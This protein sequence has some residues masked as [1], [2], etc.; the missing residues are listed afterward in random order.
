MKYC[1]TINDKRYEIEVER[2][3]AT[4]VSTTEIPLGAV[5]NKNPVNLQTAATSVT[6]KVIETPEQIT[7]ESPGVGREV[8]KAPMAGGITD[9]KV[10]VG[11][12]VRIGDTLIILEAMKMENDITAHVDGIVTEIKVTRGENVSVGDV[13]VVLK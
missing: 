6:P 11:S 1:V 13:L 7:E 3:D 10:S 12:S 9:I 2:G 4:I 8:V 5:E